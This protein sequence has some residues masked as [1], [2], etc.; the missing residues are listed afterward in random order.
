VPATSGK[1]AAVEEY[2]VMLVET[3]LV[4]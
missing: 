3:D 1:D 2:E 4:V